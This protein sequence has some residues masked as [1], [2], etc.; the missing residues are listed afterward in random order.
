MSDTATVAAVTETVPV[1]ETKIDPPKESISAMLSAVAKEKKRA[2]TM[3]KAAKDAQSLLEQR[4]TKIK[5]LESKYSYKPKDPIE[6]LQRAG[7]TYEEA[8][9]FILN[10]KKPTPEILHK[11][12]EEKIQ[13]IVTSQEARD[14]ERADNE[15]KRAKEQEQK[16][17]DD[18]KIGITEFA[19]SKEDEYE[20]L[21]KNE[22]Y[23]LVFG[24]I[25]QFYETHKRVLDKAEAC[26]M[27]E[28]YLEGEVD[29]NAQAKKFKTKYKITDATDEKKES[30]E[31]VTPKTLSNNM[32]S[33]AP[34][35]LPAKTE[36]DRIQRALAALA[37]SG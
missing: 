20:Y 16:V 22:A 1:V 2:L 23:E 9:D 12:L 10:G 32:T 8:T 33:S 36:N 3:S 30:K 24:T 11:S 25:E 18:F 15:I 29:K 35:Y 37:K 19:K 27:V 17:I 14:K 4:E 26:K 34:S 6:A 5:E 21:N 7:F 28:D 13:N 31:D